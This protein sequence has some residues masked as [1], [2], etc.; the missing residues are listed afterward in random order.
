MDLTEEYARSRARSDICNTLFAVGDI[1]YA[2]SIAVSYEDLWERYDS[3]MNL[4]G[5]RMATAAQHKRL[6]LWVRSGSIGRMVRFLV[7]FGPLA[8]TQRPDL[9][10][11][12]ANPNAVSDSIY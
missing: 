2:H 5:K 7:D 6:A 12:L 4:M 3:V 1:D 10:N 9:D 11:F 8:R